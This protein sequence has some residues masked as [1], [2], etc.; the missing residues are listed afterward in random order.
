MARQVVVIQ[1]IYDTPQWQDVAHRIIALRHQIRQDVMQTALKIPTGTQP[2]RQIAHNR[3][4]P[5]DLNN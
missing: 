1:A 5:L 3:A 4:H 2:S